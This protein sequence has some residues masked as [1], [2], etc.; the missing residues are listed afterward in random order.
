MFLFYAKKTSTNSRI[1][2]EDETKR[3][4]GENDDSYLYEER[5]DR[6][7]SGNGSRTMNKLNRD[8]K[9]DRSLSRWSGATRRNERSY[10]RFIDIPLTSYW[11]P[12]GVLAAR[13]WKRHDFVNLP[14]ERHRVQTA[15]EFR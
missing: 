3:K 5:I 9:A 12:G 4:E 14:R 8:E 13:A 11:Q 1:V 10:T 6:V 15:W 2:E 7:I